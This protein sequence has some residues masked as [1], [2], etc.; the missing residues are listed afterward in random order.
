MAEQDE[1]YERIVR[2]FPEIYMTIVGIIQGLTLGYLVFYID[3]QYSKFGLSEW[4]LTFNVFL[5]IVVTW[6]EYAINTLTF[7]W[8]PGMLDA[9]VPLCIGASEVFTI[10]SIRWLSSWLFGTGAI[11]AFA[12]LAFYN[13]FQERKNAGAYN[14]RALLKALKTHEWLAYGLT[15]AGAIIA[16]AAGAIVVINDRPSIIKLTHPFIA[17]NTLHTVFPFM[18]TLIILVF[19]I[20]GMAYWNAIKRFATKHNASVVPTLP[21]RSADD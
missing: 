6:T 7:R 19:F 9:V 2:S 16:I 14:S 13:L 15:V 3:N 11:S 21:R 20:R 18:F 10:H 8:I 12:W 1:V 4:A 5:A 17:P